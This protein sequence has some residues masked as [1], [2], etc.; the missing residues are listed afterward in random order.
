MT[1]LMEHKNYEAKEGTQNIKSTKQHVTES[2][3]QPNNQS[4]RN[5]NRK[6]DEKEQEK[7]GTFF[8]GS[9]VK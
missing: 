8:R 7:K 6:K 2:H 3:S 5:K 4:S 1:N 9:M